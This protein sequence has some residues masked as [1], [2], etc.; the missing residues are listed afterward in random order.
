M[1]LASVQ[2]TLLLRGSN[3]LSFATLVNACRVGVFVLNLC[4]GRSK[5]P[6]GNSESNYFLKPSI[7]HP[8]VSLHPEVEELSVIYV[9]VPQIKTKEFR[10]KAGYKCTCRE[11]NEARRPHVLQQAVCVRR[12]ITKKNTKSRHTQNTPPNPQQPGD[13]DH[14]EASCDEASPRVCPYSPAS[15]DPR[16][17]WKSASYSSRNQ[18]KPRMI[19]IHTDKHRQTHRLFKYR[20]PLRTP[21]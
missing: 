16:S 18:Q 20:H 17:M 14:L 1:H 3:V 2:G 12:K 9:Y 7:F 6:A 11:E 19:H 15:I 4:I 5:F 21:V 13:C 8:A 10:D